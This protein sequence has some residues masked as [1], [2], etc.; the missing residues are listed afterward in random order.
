[1]AGRGLGTAF[2]RSTC[3]PGVGAALDVILT[4]SGRTPRSSPPR[5]LVGAGPRACPAPTLRG[6]YRNDGARLGLPDSGAEAR[7]HPN[8]LQWQLTALRRAFG[9]RRP[10]R[11]G[12]P[13]MRHEPPQLRPGRRR[14]HR[15]GPD[16][17]A[18]RAVESRTVAQT[19]AEAPCSAR[20]S[21]IF[22]IFGPRCRPAA[23]PLTMLSR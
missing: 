8:E 1:M 6:S 15:G 19:P 14:A 9:P 3:G 2:R 5:R 4:R 17:V 16:G 7:S 21:A 23:E 13:H 12:R 18:G 11:A 22:A 20:S 10:A